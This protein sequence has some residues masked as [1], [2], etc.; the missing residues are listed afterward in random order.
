MLNLI[1]VWPGGGLCVLK[2][3]K[4]NGVWI[5]STFGL[6]N[7]DMPADVRSEDNRQGVDTDGRATTNSH[8]LVKKE[9]PPNPVPGRAG[10]GYELLV[11]TDQKDDW[12]IDVLQELVN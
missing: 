6:S 8:R 10:Y 5:T 2:A 12:A 7:P 9:H 4:L 11:V 1:G 3:D